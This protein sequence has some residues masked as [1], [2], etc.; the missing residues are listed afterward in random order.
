MEDK[1]FD[2]EGELRASRPRPRAD[3][4]TALADEVRRPKR[5]RQSRMGLMLALTGLMIV[6]VASFGGVG[7][8]SS[9]EPAKANHRVSAA[10]A[11]YDVYT[12]K[13]AETNGP[14]E[15]KGAAHAQGTVKAKPA[16]KTTAAQLPFTGLTL[17]IPL[18]IG[19]VLIAFG[20]GLR[21]RGRRRGTPAH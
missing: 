4:A 3:F 1:R 16:P 19:L 18:A 17:W 5:A 9:N 7:Y 11:Q 14:A 12:P 6:A 13:A 10:Q 8:A 15:T 21:T 20:V 2:L